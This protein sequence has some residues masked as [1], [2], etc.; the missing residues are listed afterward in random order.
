[1]GHASCYV[2]IGR[3]RGTNA[4]EGVVSAVNPEHA[5]AACGVDADIPECRVVARK[6]HE[7]FSIAGS[8]SLNVP[9]DNQ[10]LQPDLDVKPDP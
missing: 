8:V 1:M 3:C 5:E 6:H 10:A 7:A 4:H 9:H 2:S